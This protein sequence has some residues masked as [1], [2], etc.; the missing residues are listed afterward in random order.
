MVHRFLIH[1]RRFRS[2]GAFYT[3]S[4]LRYLALSLFEIFSTIYIIQILQNAGASAHSALGITAIMI[5]VIYLF[6]A[7]FTIPSIWLINKKGLNASITVGNGFLMVRIVLLSL[8]TYNPIF[9]VFSAIATGIEIAFYW[10][11]YHIYFSELTDD[12]KQGE[13]I[14]IGSALPGLAVVAG[15]VIGGYIITYVGFH[16]VFIVMSFILLLATIPLRYL[17]KGKVN[18]H[19][20]P[21]DIFSILSSPKELKDNIGVTGQAIIDG[22]ATHF[23][24][25]Y[26]FAIFT[27]YINLGFVGTLIGFIS[28]IGALFIGLAIDKVGPK[29]TLAVISILDAVT[30]IG[31]T[32]VTTPTGAV[33]ASGSQALT[34]AGQNITIDTMLYEKA[35]NITIIGYVMQ[36]E[37]IFAL[38]KATFFIIMGYLFYLGFALTALFYI[39]AGAALLTRL[40]NK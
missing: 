29:K 21:T 30:W 16:G 3:H 32:L 31:K 17:P 36:R 12:K 11:A 5:A 2:L 40:Y 34:V 28:M 39:C 24:P 9:I 26:V 6:H 15:P 13:E 19:I 10:T 22:S 38:T 37:L 14:A 20:K 35:R 33:L 8:A 27:G 23:W 25:V 7:L 4:V 1:Y 18:P